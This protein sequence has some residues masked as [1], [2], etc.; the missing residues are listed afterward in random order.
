MEH[1]SPSLICIYGGGKIHRGINII[2]SH[3]LIIDLDT[4]FY[5]LEGYKYGLQ[6]LSKLHHSCTTTSI[7]P[8]V[9]YKYD[10]SPMTTPPSPLP[11]PSLHYITF[12]LGLTA[13]VLAG[14]TWKSISTGPEVAANWEKPALTQ[15]P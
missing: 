1:V 4:L 10:F 12:L 9:W 14:G 3:H 6:I 5:C 15:H 2:S 7:Q 8:L 11:V 13:S